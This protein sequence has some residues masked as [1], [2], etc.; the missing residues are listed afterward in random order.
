[1]G[2][3]TATEEITEPDEGEAIQEKNATLATAVVQDL[4]CLS[5]LMT[6][7]VMTPNAVCEALYRNS[8][9]V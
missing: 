2:C 9:Y 3:V 8:S 1:M 7:T 4:R 6:L 5:L